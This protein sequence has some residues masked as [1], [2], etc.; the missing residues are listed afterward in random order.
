MRRKI[1]PIN[2][3]S[4]IEPRGLSKICPGK[5]L[6]GQFDAIRA[7]GASSQAAREE[8]KTSKYFCFDGD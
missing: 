5:A 1:S 2:E 8:R 6:V 7:V 4:A 3:L